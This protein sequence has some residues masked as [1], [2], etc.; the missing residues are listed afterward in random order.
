MDERTIEPRKR[1]GQLP[2]WRGRTTEVG[3]FVHRRR[4]RTPRRLGLVFVSNSGSTSGHGSPSGGFVEQFSA[5]AR[6]CRS[7]G[8]EFL[9]GLLR[10]PGNS[11]NIS[12][13]NKPAKAAAPVELAPAQP[14]VVKSEPPQIPS[15]SPVRAEVT[16]RAAAPIELEANAQ[17]AHRDLSLLANSAALANIGHATESTPPYPRPPSRSSGTSVR[18]ER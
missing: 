8:S 7:D 18:S 12:A 11:S 13:Q 16:Q 17:Q 15:R 3:S 4:W 1:C 10:E 5:I 9:L 6:N 14:A 2:K